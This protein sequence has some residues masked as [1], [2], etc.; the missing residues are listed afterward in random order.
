MLFK[1]VTSYWR[2]LFQPKGNLKEG[3]TDSVQNLR[4]R[5]KT[6]PSMERD[7][8]SRQ[9]VTIAYTFA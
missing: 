9:T 3:Y 1:Q 8:G 5:S 7:L 4:T 2:N 6:E